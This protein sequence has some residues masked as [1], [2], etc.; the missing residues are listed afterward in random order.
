MPIMASGWH[1]RSKRPSFAF[2]KPEGERETPGRN[3][4]PLIF[5]NRC[6]KAPDERLVNTSRQHRS[7]GGI[8]LLSSCAWL[9]GRVDARTIR[10]QE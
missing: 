2:F 7:Q 8:L 5:P 9:C 10:V 4:G 6:Q 1:S 3:P